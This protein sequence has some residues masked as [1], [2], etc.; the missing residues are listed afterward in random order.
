MIN[1]FSEGNTKIG[2]N[3]DLGDPLPTYI[4][5]DHDANTDPKLCLNSRKMPI[6]TKKAE[7]NFI[8]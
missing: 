6:H 3:S 1:V 8:R 4:I 2:N 7:V 5:N